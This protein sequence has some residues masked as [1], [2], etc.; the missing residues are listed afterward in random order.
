MPSRSPFRRAAL[1]LILCAAAAWGQSFN[2]DSGRERVV[3][4]DGG[5]RF[6]PGDSPVSDGS[7]AWA[8]P[9]FD[10][11]SWKLL[12]STKPWSEQGY[13][14]MGG[15]GWY[16]FTI[17][18]P[19]GDKPTDLLLAPTV[20]SYQ[21][22][23]E[24]KLV[25]SR[26]PMPPRT[27]PSPEFNVHIFP[28]SPGGPH[29][30]Q[31]VVAA[32]RM[33]HAPIW[34]NYIGGGPLKS[35][36]LAGDPAL[37][38]AQQ[39]HQLLKRDVLFVDA[40]SFSII[41]ALVGI[42]ILCLFLMRPAEREYLWFAC[43]LLALSA[44]NV[45][46]IGQQLFAWFPEPVYDIADAALTALMICAALR[47][48]AR[49]LGI[50]AGKLGRIAFVLAA[51]SPPASVLYWP[52]W[53][54]PA[55]SASIQ[56]ALLLPAVLWILATLV[57]AAIRG[58]LDARLLLLP[59]LLDFG[60]Y[61]ADNLA[62]VLAQAGITGIPSMRVFEVT[63][64]LPP[65]K[66]QAGY[67]IHL[68][69]LL[70]LLVYLIRRYSLARRQ[71]ER[72]ASEFEAARQIQLVLLPDQKDQCP[73]FHVESIYWPADQVGGD[74]YQ[75]IADGQGGITIVLGD[76]SG[77]GLPAAMIVSVLVGAIR[78]EL[79]HGADPVTLLAS[80]NDRV[81]GR[82]HGGFV[83]CLAAH[84]SGDGLLTIANAGHL[85]PYLDGQEIAA[86][87]SL[88]LGLLNSSQY[89]SF[90]VQLA[91][92]DRLTFVSDG[93]VEAQSRSGELLGFD[94]TRALSVQSAEAIASAAKRHGQQDDI[95]VVTIEYRGVPCNDAPT[96]FLGETRPATA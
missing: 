60:F 29:P 36:H 63:I 67:L 39:Q 13:T 96:R 35:G 1:L 78:A 8:A 82:S 77:K 21:V 38:R 50:P 52:Q 2:L 20:S 30:T 86:P 10:D 34:A 23:V 28:L 15:F 14:D 11:S 70:A 57:R 73:G 94:Q 16:R 17:H 31:D 25:G 4:L 76:V 33:W 88:P 84:L 49:V 90:T 45:C 59:T 42:A 80:L 81:M 72:L 93:V 74:F 91:A 65:F 71:E 92:G 7:F 83:T 62:T 41:S 56:I 61:F 40:Y 44:D 26:G 69:F 58:N 3:S 87:G 51:I 64:P 43:M 24:G 47:F 19:A 48:F 54:S 79:A 22:Y 89:E 85:P 6:H 32:L 53:A 46:Y 27:L 75:Q 18:I 55:A 37:L 9:S 95:T 12:D 68:V 5:W 66:L